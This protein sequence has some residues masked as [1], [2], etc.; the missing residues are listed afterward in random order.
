MAFEQKKKK[1][2]PRTWAKFNPGLS[3]YRPSNNQ[4]LITKR[5]SQKNAKITLP[6]PYTLTK[7]L[8]NAVVRI[9]LDR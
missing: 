3:A 2:K 1:K 5:G 6:W 8:K 9:R 4:A 7:D